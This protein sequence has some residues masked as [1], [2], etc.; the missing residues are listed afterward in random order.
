MSKR[1]LRL[2]LLVS[3]G[4]LALTALA[5]GIG[6]LTGHPDLRVC[7]GA[8]DWLAARHRPQPA[9]VLRH[10][11]HTVL[12]AGGWLVVVEPSHGNAK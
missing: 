1:F 5:G 3:T 8:G 11:G 9:G 6:L 7:G 2:F 10:P 12:P 4:F